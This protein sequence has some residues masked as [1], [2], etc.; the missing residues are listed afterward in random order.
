MAG[1]AAGP[2][3]PASGSAGSMGTGPRARPELGASRLKDLPVQWPLQLLATSFFIRGWKCYQQLPPLP[4]AVVLATCGEPAAGAL[5]R[6]PEA[7]LSG[8]GRPRHGVARKVSGVS[9]G[10]ASL[11]WRSSCGSCV[12]APLSAELLLATA[13]AREGLIT[14]AGPG[15]RELP[16]IR[17]TRG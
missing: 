12:Q 16:G 7:G 15:G 1:R 6:R 8:R 2:C 14:V 9:S 10:L 5:G 4:M 17:L 13:H 3:L 11:T